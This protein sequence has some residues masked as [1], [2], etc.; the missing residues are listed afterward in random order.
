VPALR[1]WSVM[2]APTTPDEGDLVASNLVVTRVAEPAGVRLHV[3][4]EIDCASAPAFL[5]RLRSEIE[6]GGRIVL[7]LDQVTFIDSVGLDTLVVA[8]R[9]AGDR[10][11]LGALHPSVH[12][13]LHI[14]ALLDELTGPPDTAADPDSSA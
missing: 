3:A 4:G 11:R 10:V 1:L 9:L 12:R 13:V 7:E 14:T 2:G 6:G 5:Q 8:R